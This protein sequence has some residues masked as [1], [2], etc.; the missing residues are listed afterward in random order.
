MKRTQT[1]QSKIFKQ[2]STIKQTNGGTFEMVNGIEAE[3]DMKIKYK[4]NEIICFF[5]GKMFM[6][7]YSVYLNI[8]LNR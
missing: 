1:K 6:E 3:H 7:I 2:C 5:F 4:K 8:T